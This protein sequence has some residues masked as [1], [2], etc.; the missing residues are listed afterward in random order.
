MGRLGDLLHSGQVRKSAKVT[1]RTARTVQD[2]GCPGRQDRGRSSDALPPAPSV[3]RCRQMPPGPFWR[4]VRA[5]LRSRC[6]SPSLLST[7]A[8]T[9]NPIVRAAH[10]LVSAQVAP[11]GQRCLAMHHDKTASTAG[12][13]HRARF[14]RSVRIQLPGHETPGKT[15][16]NA[17]SR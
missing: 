12:L 6:Y 15:S 7:A 9:S 4:Q 16:R 10:V 2:T 1:I 8:L 3:T 5:W 11:G 17:R 14:R 13:K